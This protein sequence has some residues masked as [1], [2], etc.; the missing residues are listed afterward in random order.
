MQHQFHFGK[1]FY[2]DHKTG[3]W[4]STD[5]PRV[6][7][8]VWVWRNEKGPIPRKHHVHHI[9]GNKS[10]ND[11]SNLDCL[12]ERDHYRLHLTDEKRQWARKWIEE[13]RPLTKEWHKS[14]EGRKW[15]RQHAKE[16]NWG[17]FDLPLK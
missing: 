2:L 10:N 12:H 17:K 8:H 14:E 1:K 4:I 9:D 3:Y 7:A 16:M 6:R 5:H 15:H 11:I 13:I